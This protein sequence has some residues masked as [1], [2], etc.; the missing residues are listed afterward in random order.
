MV[1]SIGRGHD[2]ILAL[3]NKGNTIQSQLASQT[4]DIYIGV[5]DE[6]N[7]GNSHKEIS[8]VSDCSSLDNIIEEHGTSACTR[9]HS[10]KT[11]WNKTKKT[12]KTTV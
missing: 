10:V 6:I 8:P 9:G 5:D 4:L 3:Y 11:R 2:C 7:G 12:P 1:K